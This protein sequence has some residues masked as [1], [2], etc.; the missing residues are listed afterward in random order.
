MAKAALEEK[1]IQ[2]K[3]ARLETLQAAEAPLVQEVENLD[4]YVLLGTGTSPAIGDLPLLWNCFI[5]LLFFGNFSRF[6]H[7]HARAR[8]GHFFSADPNHMMRGN[9]QLD[10]RNWGIDVAAIRILSDAAGRIQDAAPG[11]NWHKTPHSFF[12]HESGQ[13]REPAVSTVNLERGN[14]G[15]SRLVAKYGNVTGLTEVRRVFW[16]DSHNHPPWRPHTIAIFFFFFSSSSF[17]AAIIFCYWSRAICG[18]TLRTIIYRAGIVKAL[19]SSTVVEN[20]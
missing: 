16:C 9:V 12:D 15:K 4:N 7:T 8:A 17:A 11:S 18:S 6:L 10:G 20:I 19:K 3:Q 1:N 14:F 13:L 5:S 2:Q